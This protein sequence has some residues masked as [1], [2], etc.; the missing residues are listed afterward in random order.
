M[1]RRSSGPRRVQLRLKTHA[2]VVTT[3]SEATPR[4][5]SRGLAIHGLDVV[6]MGAE[7]VR[8]GYLR[9]VKVLVLSDCHIGS[10][11]RLELE[12]PLQEMKAP[13]LRGFLLVRPARFELATSASAGQRSIP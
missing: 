6:R 9:D 13:C 1:A 10:Q 11:L 2:P 5:V 3:P 4:A 7:E 8:G 12:P